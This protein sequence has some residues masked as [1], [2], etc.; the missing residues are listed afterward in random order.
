[1]NNS[2]P[3]VRWVLYN[4]ESKLQSIPV[5]HEEI[6][7]TVMRMKQ[8]DWKKYYI[9]RDGWQNWQQLETY[10]KSNQKEIIVDFKKLEDDEIGVDTETETTATVRVD[11][12]SIENT[13]D[14]TQFAPKA[15][16]QPKTDSNQ[17]KAVSAAEQK[18]K[19][20][21][22][23][24]FDTS[25]PA[26][27]NTTYVDWDDQL[28]KLFVESAQD[29]SGDSLNPEDKQNGAGSA[30][31]FKEEK[32]AKNNYS[33]R[34][35]RHTLKIE[36]LFVNSKGKTFKSFSR[37]ISMSGTLI[38]ED[39]PQAFMEQK[40]EIVIINRF[41]KTTQNSRLQLFAK[42]PI[43]SAPN[44]IQF[45]D[46]KDHQKTKLKSLLEQYLIDQKNLMSRAS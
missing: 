20:V 46:V 37:N 19:S 36:V 39:I 34:A 45:L 38:D 10:L 22:K 41:S 21:N 29:F 27:K 43:L 18:S 3:L 11:K 8:V 30:I 44:R 5:N 32:L 31:N 40:L 26:T 1:M 23:N 4:S 12:F 2:E 6:Q 28:A 9:W 14:K 35:E 15:I 16:V 13:P 33:N 17:K 7:W 24:I 42:C 25:R